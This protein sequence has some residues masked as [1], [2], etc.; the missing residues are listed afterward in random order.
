[1]ADTK[2]S[3]DRGF[4]DAPFTL[5]I[6]NDTPGAAIRYTLDGSAPTATT[7]SVYSGPLT[8]SSTSIVRAAAFKADYQPGNINTQ[9]YIFPNDVILQSTMSTIITNDP[10]WGP[11]M[12]AAML[13]IPTISLVTQSALVSGS[14]VETSVELLNPDGTEGFQID[15]G[16][17]L[18]GGVSLTKLPK[19][20]IR[21][22][23]KGIYGATKLNYDLFGDG[24]TTQFD[25]ILLR[26]ESFD[27]AFYSNGTWGAYLRSNLASDLQLAMGEPAEHERFVHV[28]INGV[29]NGEYSLMERPD[30]AFM[31]SYFGGSKDDYDVIKGDNLAF[32]PPEALDG[33]LVAWNAMVAAITSGD[34]QSVKQYMDVTNYADY[35]LREFYEGNVWD[36]KP[37]Q[38]WMAARK[39][40]P[41][42]GFIFFPWDADNDL[43]GKGPPGTSTVVDGLYANSI[44]IGGPANL[45]PSMIQFPE[46]KMLVADR[47]Q[48]FFFNGGIFTTASAQAR[49]DSIAGQISLSILGECARWGHNPGVAMN[50]TLPD[51]TPASWQSVIDLMRNH[52]MAGR[53]TVVIQQMLDAGIFPAISSPAF[54]Q[55]GG[56]VPKNFSVTLSATAGTIYY[57]LDGSDPRLSG[58][59]VSPSALIYQPASPITIDDSTLIKVRALSGSVWSAI[60]EAQFIVDTPAS[61]SH[62]VVSELQYNPPDPTA[63]ELAINPAWAGKDFEFIELKNISNSQIDLTNVRFTVG[64]TF[65]FTGGSVIKVAPGDY[66]LVVSNLGAF[67]ARYGTSRLSRVAGTY[68]GNLSN[69][70]ELVTL[71]DRLNVNIFS[72]T[73]G[74]S[75]AWPGRADGNGSSLELIDPAAVPTIATDARPICKTPPTGVPAA[76]T[77]AAR[78]RRALGPFRASWSTKC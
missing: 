43:R 68:S 70:G 78:Q 64:I 28:Y 3:V 60:D 7:G 29:Y 54:S 62:L 15:A 72:F 31:A 32:N 48:K 37:Y 67:Q 69:S 53:E 14:E 20:S 12:R 8:M 75:G 40:E 23:F 34:Y 16:G 41:G 26:G 24:A 21:I 27:S 36:W 33:N 63:A 56:V 73:F 44:G 61:I 18:F 77:T 55:R 13:A 2:F 74:D 39:R 59:A 47:A 5:T 25:E 46:F 57:T 42:A 22:S 11:Q 52:I 66:V 4:F 6:T 45:W 51:Y 30:N 19:K 71:V 58:G 38:N 1:M 10:V 35:M 49:L 65:N 17:E 76:N 50:Q 9:T